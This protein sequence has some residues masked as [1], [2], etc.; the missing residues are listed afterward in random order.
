MERERGVGAQSGCVVEG[1]GACG[2]FGHRA[3]M[4]YI[5]IALFLHVC[6][7][8]VLNVSTSGK[9]CCILPNRTENSARGCESL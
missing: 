9:S 4:M 7:D 2:R 5:C 3:D 1:F 6:L 8:D